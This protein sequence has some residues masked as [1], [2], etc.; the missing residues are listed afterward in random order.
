MTP[1]QFSNRR[2]TI[3]GEP[4]ILVTSLAILSSSVEEALLQFPKGVME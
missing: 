2:T 1:F 4:S 3:I